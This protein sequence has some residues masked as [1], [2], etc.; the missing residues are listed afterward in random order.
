MTLSHARGPLIR[1]RGAIKAL[2]RRAAVLKSGATGTHL[3]R[4]T[5]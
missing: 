4:S 2:P 1:R 3:E 5:K